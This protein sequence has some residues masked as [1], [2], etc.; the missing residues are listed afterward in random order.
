[1]N[2]DMAAV[3]EVVREAAR[4]AVRQELRAHNLIDGATHLKHHEFL[5]SW[6]KAMD[7]AR[8]T[9]IKVVVT[10]LLGGIFAVV[11]YFWRGTR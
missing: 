11:V 5:A 4:E 6:C 2:G 1:M 9:T 10:A 7:L 8:S 3:R